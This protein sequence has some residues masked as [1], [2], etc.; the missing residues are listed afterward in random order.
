MRPEVRKLGPMCVQTRNAAGELEI[1]P[2]P[3]F[4]VGGPVMRTPLPR[5][6]PIVDLPAAVAAPAVL[7]SSQPMQSPPPA[8]HAVTADVSAPAAAKTAAKGQRE[9]GVAIP[10][11]EVQVAGIVLGPPEPDAQPA[12]LATVSA[13]GQQDARQAG[14]AAATA[15]VPAACPS[16][17]S[18]EVADG[19]MPRHAGGGAAP[20]TVSPGV[21]QPQ[22]PAGT[23]AA[24]GNAAASSATVTQQAVCDPP[25][26]VNVGIGVPTKTAQAPA[27]GVSVAPQLAATTAPSAHVA[28]AA[29]TAVAAPTSGVSQPSRVDGGVAA[30]TSEG[31][32]PALQVDPSMSALEPSASATV[33]GGVVLA[34]RGSALTAQQPVMSPFPASSGWSGGRNGSE[35]AVAAQRAAFE[36]AL[37]MALEPDFT[38]LA[39]AQSA[40]PLRG[41][42]VRPP[43]AA[44]VLPAQLP[45]AP[46]QMPA[47][48]A[49]TA[50][51]GA[52]LSDPV[53]MFLN[54][55]P[56]K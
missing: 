36:A 23:P 42:A 33:S 20:P 24:A 16:A 10:A 1:A 18:A 55:G 4:T 12:P 8:P 32:F 30:G 13:G 17:A 45:R 11:G 44:P 48:H 3:A 27:D 56:D 29:A 9:G 34:A 37:G 15:A 28:T 26:A 49:A 43:A 53:A 6:A 40:V 50:A 7:P 5:L 22:Q 46:L 35:M 21:S 39:R 31:A 38:A 41:A 52:A 19:E 25:S 51:A 47:Q 14:D 54:D 2:M